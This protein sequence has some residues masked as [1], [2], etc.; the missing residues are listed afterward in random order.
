MTKSI[1]FLGTSSKDVFASPERKIA[2]L[3]WLKLSLFVIFISIS[4]SLFDPKLIITFY[5]SK[6]YD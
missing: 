4:F 6:I 3:E 2:L 1:K 5:K